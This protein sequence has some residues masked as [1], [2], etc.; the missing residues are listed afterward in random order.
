MSALCQCNLDYI[1]FNSGKPLASSIFFIKQRN[2]LGRRHGSLEKLMDT[3]YTNWNV[4]KKKDNLDFIF[5]PKNLFNV[6]ISFVF[7]QVINIDS[8]SSEDQKQICS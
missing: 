2:P 7:R 5:K 8:G 3:R 4:I 1:L 6:S